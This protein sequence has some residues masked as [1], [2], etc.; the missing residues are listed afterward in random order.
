VKSPTDAG[1]SRLQE[2]EHARYDGEECHDSHRV[3]D[4]MALVVAVQP[5][6][7]KPCLPSTGLVM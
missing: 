3:C 5:G 4:A 1:P 7:V 2:I 6:D